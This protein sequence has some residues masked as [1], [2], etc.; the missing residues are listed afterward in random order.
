MELYGKASITDCD[1]L[2]LTQL[3]NKTILVTGAT[4]LIGYNFLQQLMTVHKE[5]NLKILAV[6]RDKERARQIFGTMAEEVELIVG[7]VRQPLMLSEPV[8]YIVHGASM[9]A[10]K[11]FVDQPVETI[12]TALEGTVNLLKLAAQNPGCSMV[13][14]SSMEVYGTVTEKRLLTEQDVSYLDPLQLR[15][16]YPQSKRLCESLCVAYAAE[17]GINVKIAR[18]VQTFGP[19]MQAT[20]R[21]AI[22]EFVSAALKNEDI[23]IKTSGKSARMYLY[24]FDAVTAILTLLLKGKA[25]T[26]YNLADKNTYL[27]I[28][29]LAA[30]IVETLHATSSVLV[31][32][33]SKNE[34]SIYPPDTYL[35]L[36]TSL[37]ESLGWCPQFSFRDS[38]QRIAE[39]LK[40]ER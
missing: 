34:Q 13:Y 7:D 5:L 23:S 19:G 2:P 36:D 1:W 14:L 20:D 29:D 30:E 15:S 4:G 39:T 25:G 28:Y 6:V 10:S 11:S 17:Y 26:A 27:S 24:T 31:N 12:M 18:L 37:L 22:T 21:R 8:Q 33:G 38:V 40:M 35:Y 32:T 16:S 3:K 9:T